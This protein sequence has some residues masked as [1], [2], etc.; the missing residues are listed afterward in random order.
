MVS[1]RWFHVGGVTVEALGEGLVLT[2][3]SSGRVL[4]L[5]HGTE[6]VLASSANSVGQSV[7]LMLAMMLALL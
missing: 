5:E 1:V 6:V 3:T 4:D 2:L 7:C